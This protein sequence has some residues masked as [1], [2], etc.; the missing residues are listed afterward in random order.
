MRRHVEASLGARSLD[1]LADDAAD[2]AADEH[3]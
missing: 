2:D 1:R 3:R